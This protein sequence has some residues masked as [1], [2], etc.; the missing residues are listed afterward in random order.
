[1][2]VLVIRTVAFKTLLQETPK[3]AIEMLET[4]AF[5]PPPEGT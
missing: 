1:V 4:F 5:R 3:I 2:R